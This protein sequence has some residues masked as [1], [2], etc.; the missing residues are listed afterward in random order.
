MERRARVYGCFPFCLPAKVER[1]EK[2][3]SSDDY[4]TVVNVSQLAA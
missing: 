2:D 4:P 3:E 1:A